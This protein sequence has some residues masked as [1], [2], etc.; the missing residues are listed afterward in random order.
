MYTDFRKVP[1]TTLGT[2]ETTSKMNLNPATW[3]EREGERERKFWV[4]NFIRV[5][6]YMNAQNLGG[7]AWRYIVGQ[8]SGGEVS[9]FQAF[10]TKKNQTSNTYCR[11]SSGFKEQQLLF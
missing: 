11:R 2:N 10:K 3:Y 4:Y 6:A 5:S 8:K 9:P 7:S 1:V